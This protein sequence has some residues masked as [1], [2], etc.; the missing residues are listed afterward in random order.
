MVVT[1]ST[2]ISNMQGR[3]SQPLVPHKV[4]ENVL[5]HARFCLVDSAVIFECHPIVDFLEVTNIKDS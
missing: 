3:C 4:R 5:N 2:K 1:V